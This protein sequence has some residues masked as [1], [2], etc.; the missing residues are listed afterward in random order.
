[1]KILVLGQ[2]K[3]GKSTFGNALAEATGLLAA[4]SSWLAM[5]K[6]VWPYLEK[7]YMSKTECYEDRL[8][9][10]TVWKALIAFYNTPDKS[11]LAKELLEVS[12]I[13]IGMRCNLE[14]EASKHLFDVIYY[15][16]AS[17][18]VGTSEGTLSIPFDPDR[19][20]KVDTN[21]DEAHLMAQVDKISTILRQALCYEQMM[22]KLKNPQQQ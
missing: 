18:R 1:M 6:A 15:C 19:M 9:N 22:H 2:D 8:N 5:E 14:Y 10:R 20:F 7:F 13:Y 17:E 4:D 11:S 21:G 16:D 3:H 12:D